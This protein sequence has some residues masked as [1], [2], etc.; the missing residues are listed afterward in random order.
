MS[1]SYVYFCFDMENEL[2]SSIVAYFVTLLSYKY[3]SHF[4]SN[5]KLANNVPTT[6]FS[7]RAIVFWRVK[8]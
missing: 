1:T 3:I 7:S 4:T 8:A 2:G 5:E 6:F